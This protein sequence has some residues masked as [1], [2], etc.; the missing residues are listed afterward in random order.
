MPRLILMTFALSLGIA[1]TAVAQPT[2]NKTKTAFTDPAS[3][4]IDF[5]LQGEYVGSLQTEQGWQRYGLQVIARGDG[6]FAGVLIL[7]GLP[8]ED[9]VRGLRTQVAGKREDDSKARLESDGKTILIDGNTARVEDSEGAYLG[10]LDK[11]TRSSPT[12]GLSPPPGAIVLFDGQDASNLEKAKVSDD[13]VIQ[14]NSIPGGMTTKMPVGAFHLHIEFRS[15]FMPY[16][17]GQSR[18]NSGVYIQRRYECQ[19]LDSFGLDGV[20]NEC[21]A[22]YRQQ[23]PYINMCLPPLTWQTYD[24]YFTPPQWDE[25]GKK[26]ANAEITVF[27]NGV[28]VHHHREIVNKTGA[29]RPEGPEKLPIQFQNHSDAVQFRNMW[30]EIKD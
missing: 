20:K 30:I 27:Q 17:T 18:G 15:P 29:G 16:A 14:I 5:Q 2:K 13:G 23:E 10:S 22:L 11:V 8:G 28:A 4:G 1:T 19:I 24:I 25:A 7:G 12:L 26:S 9:V 21:G 3:A 6:A